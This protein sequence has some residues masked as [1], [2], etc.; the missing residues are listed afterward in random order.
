MLLT[1]FDCPP[2][3]GVNCELSSA[4]GTIINVEEKVMLFTTAHLFPIDTVTLTQTV[5]VNKFDSCLTRKWSYDKDGEILSR[6]PPLLLNQDADIA[7]GILERP[8]NV[9]VAVTSIPSPKFENWW[10]DVLPNFLTLLE[11]MTLVKDG[12]SSG[13]TTGRYCKGSFDGSVFFVKG[14]QQ[15]PFSVPGDSGSLVLDLTSG[16]VVGAVSSIRFEKD[17]NSDSYL[18]EVTP[19]L[20]FYNFL[21]EALD[22]VESDIQMKLADNG[23]QC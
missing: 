6:V 13:V 22:V 2:V 19:V 8:A 12:A 20:L 21:T 7:V 4:T 14:D 9:L 5:R 23:G 11:G 16:N 17:D 1:V 15:C 10:G 3:L 18:T